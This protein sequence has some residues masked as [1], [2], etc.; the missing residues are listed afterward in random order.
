MAKATTLT[1]E[2]MEKRVLASLIDPS[3]SA[4]AKKVA[5][6]EKLDPEMFH[7]QGLADIFRSWIMMGSAAFHGMV[8]G[9][10]TRGLATTGGAL[11]TLIRHIVRDYRQ[12]IRETDRTLDEFQ[13]ATRDEDDEDCLF[14]NRWLRRGGCGMIISSSGVGKSSFTMQ[15]AVHW[16]RGAEMLGVRPLKPLKVGIVQSEDD[17]YDVANFRDKIRI[18]LRAELKWT[19]EQI[20][21][22]E[23][24]VTFCAWDGSTGER[25]VEYIRR[26]QT[27]HH[28]DLIIVNPLHAFFG[29]DLKN[30]DE[31]SRFLRNGIDSLIKNE[32]TK[33]AMLFVHHTGKPS[34]DKIAEGDFFAGYLGSGSAELINYPRV[35]L[36]LT[37]YKDGKVPGVFNLIGSKHG[38]KLAWKTA[39]G[40]PTNKRTVC[41][42]NRLAR[43]KTDGC[44]YWV[45]PDLDDMEEIEAEAE[46][47][48]KPKDDV[49]KQAAI[50]IAE[51]FKREKIVGPSDY[52]SSEKCKVPYS[53]RKRQA[54]LRL[55]ACDPFKFGLREVTEG[56]KKHYEA[57]PAALTTTT[58][59][60]ADA[61]DLNF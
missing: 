52:V 29:G 1:T 35:A 3:T 57:D 17:E 33:C 10:P 60:P 41:Y 59:D 21:E 58:N 16:A 24:R 20:A 2:D 7:T 18:G 42:A 53:K 40:K 45:A 26:K 22:A 43:H 11:K 61:A 13:V 8:C 23:A 15:A 4:A 12:R 38:D 5:E 27:M 39:D 55:I 36:T 54:A 37:P 14:K 31:V 6:E 34:K 46:A 32:E 47:N 28:F 50:A 49:Y 51:I 19:N 30:A 9:E 56:R 25:F 44:I 48:N